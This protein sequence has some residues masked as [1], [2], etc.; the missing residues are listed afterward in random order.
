M[1]VVFDVAPD[2]ELAPSILDASFDGDTLHGQEALRA[3][4]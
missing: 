3:A 2:A 4:H 1:G